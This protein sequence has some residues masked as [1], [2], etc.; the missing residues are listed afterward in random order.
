MTE[1]ITD[2]DEQVKYLE[3]LGTAELKDWTQ[4][5][6][7]TCDSGPLDIYDRDSRVEPVVDLFHK[8]NEGFKQLYR[9]VVAELLNESSEQTLAEYTS[10][11]VYLSGR[12]RAT[13]AYDWL[14][15]NANS[16]RFKG[17][18]ADREDLHQTILRVIWGM[19]IK[20]KALSVYQRNLGDPNY[21]ELC[22]N[23]LARPEG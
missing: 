3:G 4:K 9:K 11:L 20:D 14:L 18:I 12:I 21:R 15:N 2:L 5:Y 8:S 13:D 16:E 19:G 10:R 23:A 1:R 6:L 17:I 22:S 7:L